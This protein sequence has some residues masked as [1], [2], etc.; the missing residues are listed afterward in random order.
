MS[1]PV[2][3]LG[4]ILIWSTTPLTINWSLQGVDSTLAVLTRMV[5]GLLSALAILIAGRTRFP[6]HRRALL[7]YAVGGLGLFASLA[8]TYWGAR[9]IHSGLIAVI[10]GLAPLTAG[11]MARFLLGEKALSPWQLGGT[12]LGIV[13]LGVIFLHGGSQGGGD[14]VAGLL[15]LF[16]SVVFYSAGMVGLKRIGDDSPP[17]ATT[18]GALS[19]ATLMFSL[20]WMLQ[21]GSLPSSVPWR[22]AS[23]IVYLGTFGSAVAFTLYYYVIKHLPTSRIA[24]ITL[25]TPVVA[26]FLGN[27]LNGEA[28]SPK[29]LAGTAL[30]MLGL[31]VHQ[32]EVLL[33]LIGRRRV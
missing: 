26:L 29:L 15:A 19:V 4:I 27:L 31:A 8:L 22:A 11:A 12:L 7:A 23:A 33:P 24:L 30:I 20:Q 9:F 13:G 10:F 6:L 32:H 28:I 14:Y 1:V 5:V 18:V 2:A 21:P 3:Y 16:G 17:L 25:I